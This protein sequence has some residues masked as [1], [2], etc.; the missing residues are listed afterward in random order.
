MKSKLR[1]IA[2]IVLL[3]GLL[4]GSTC[5]VNDTSVK[6]LTTTFN[7]GINTS[8]IKSA[9]GLSLTLSLDAK[10]YQQGQKVNIT[11]DEKNTLFKTNNVPVSGNW[12]MDELTLAGPCNVIP[13]PFGIAILP[14]YY[15][16]ADYRKAIQLKLY[17]P[18]TYIG[19]INPIPSDFSI[20]NFKQQSDVATMSSESNPQLISTIPLYVPITLTNYWTGAYPAAV[21]HN[22]DPGVYTI[23]AGDEWGALV[24]L[25]FTVTQ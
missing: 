13:Y 22:F 12:P 2:A 7:I 3:L 21:Q 6:S 1:I 5:C 16:S 20:Y 19:C 14:G 15:T 4:I 18:D 11:I 24:I 8:S 17:K 9:N 10:T 23:V 25:H